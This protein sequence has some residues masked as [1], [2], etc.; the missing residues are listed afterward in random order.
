M[1][2]AQKLLTGFSRPTLVL[3][4]IKNIEINED[5]EFI[6]LVYKPDQLSLPPHIN[7]SNP[8]VQRTVIYDSF[9][10]GP[11]VQMRAPHLLSGWRCSGNIFCA[12]RVLESASCFGDKQKWSDEPS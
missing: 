6:K 3:N 5:F 12:V 4:L 2:C 9:P 11:E 1:S 10:M 7:M 8:R